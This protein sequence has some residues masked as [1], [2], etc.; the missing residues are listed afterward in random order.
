MHTSESGQYNCPQLLH[1]QTGRHSLTRTEPSNKRPTEMVLGGGNHLTGHTPSRGTE[2]NSRQRVLCDKGQDKLDAIFPE[3]GSVFLSLH[4]LT[5]L[6]N[7]DSP[8]T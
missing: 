2:C 8:R 4:Q 5:H 3:M 7:K 6:P 1:Q